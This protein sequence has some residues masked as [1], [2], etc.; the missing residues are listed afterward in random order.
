LS[1]HRDCSRYSV[2]CHL[3]D[4]RCDAQHEHGTTAGRS[5]AISLRAGASPTQGAISPTQSHPKM[6]GK[7]APGPRKPSELLHCEVP[8]TR[9]TSSYPRSTPR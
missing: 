3:S 6:L 7:W 1:F 2:R 4:R 9:I 8:G 5:G